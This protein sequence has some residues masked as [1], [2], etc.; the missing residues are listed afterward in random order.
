LT[1]S[2]LRTRLSKPLLF[3]TSASSS[4]FAYIAY[5]L[6]STPSLSIPVT[7]VQFS[8]D[9]FLPHADL[10]AVVVGRGWEIYA[11]A[12][13][14]LAAVV[15]WQ[16]LGVNQVERRIVAAGE[17]VSTA[18][19]TGLQTEVVDGESMNAESQ[20]WARG[21]GVSGMLAAAGAIVGAYGSAWW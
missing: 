11:V 9:S 5:Y 21:W 13:G 14:V 10:T 12:A 2:S 4:A 1:L 15:P 8:A 16:L 19:G 3:V 7:S 6:Y 20:K 18:E 17:G